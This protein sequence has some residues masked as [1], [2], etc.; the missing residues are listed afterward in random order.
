MKDGSR[1]VTA[2]TEMAGMEGDK[3]VLQEIFRFTEEGADANGKLTGQLRAV[4]IRPRFMP[5]LEATG[6][7][8]AADLF[9]PG[10]R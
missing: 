4:G 7:K 8:P 1:R 9:S 10:R 5:K 3:I 2:I 6:F